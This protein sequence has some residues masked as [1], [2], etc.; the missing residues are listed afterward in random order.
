M[1]PQ[2]N[3]DSSQF[4]TDCEEYLTLAEQSNAA[5]SQIVRVLQNIITMRDE[6]A[7]ELNSLIL[8]SIAHIEPEIPEVVEYPDTLL[9]RSIVTAICLRQPFLRFRDTV[10]SLVIPDE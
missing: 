7:A 4:F 5:D 2:Y 1:I 9:G 6:S 8:Q 10:A 3:G